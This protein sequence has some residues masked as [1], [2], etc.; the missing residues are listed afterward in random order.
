[1]NHILESKM[2]VNLSRKAL[3]RRL[4][5]LSRQEAEEATKAKDPCRAHLEGRSDAYGVAAALVRNMADPAPQLAA[6]LKAWLKAVDE[7]GSTIHERIYGLVETAELIHQA[8][9]A[10]AAAGEEVRG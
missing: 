7:S 5:E 9:A 4:V 8:R 6:A 1:M 10:L 3:E 2:I